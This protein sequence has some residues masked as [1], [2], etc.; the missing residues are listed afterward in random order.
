MS[1]TGDI[2]ELAGHSP[3]LPLSEQIN[4]PGPFQPELF[5]ASGE[6]LLGTEQM[7]QNLPL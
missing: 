2:S 4:H 1:V 6:S 5:C 7:K 3:G